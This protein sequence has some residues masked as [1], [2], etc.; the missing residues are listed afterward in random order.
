MEPTTKKAYA[1]AGVDIHLAD[2]VKKT[3]AQQART[4]FRGE[5]IGSEFFG[6]MF[7]LRGYREPVL[8]S[9]TDGVGTKLRIASLL[10]KNDT[11]GMDIVNHCVNDILCC[12]AEPLFFLD[13]IAMG[14][15]VPEQIEAIVSGIV[16][17]CRETGCSLI[18][19]E[20]AEM[21]GIYSQGN[22]DLVGFIVGVVEKKRILDGSSITPDDVILGLSSSGLHTNGYSLVRKTFGI[23]ANPSCLNKFYPEL[24]KTLG[25]ELLQV[26]LCYYPQLK[27]VLPVIKCMAHI[28][29]GGFIGNIPRILPE[30]VAARIKKD[31]WDIPPIFR[32][33]QK[34]G[35]TKEEEMYQVFNMGIGMTI[36][37]SPEQVAKIVNILPQA[38]VIGEIIKG[39]DKERVLIE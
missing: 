33:I 37:C 35:N 27:P 8:V 10:G 15:L 4:T 36:I 1:L 38:R 34:E 29:G 17:A 19:G 3:I 32:L 11:V 21:P 30:G 20:T 39:R 14:K 2:K 25:E 31:S 6:S 12:G 7:Q 22:Y 16:R 26:H 9:S 5:V 23:D 13:Y 28:T 24:G 18:G